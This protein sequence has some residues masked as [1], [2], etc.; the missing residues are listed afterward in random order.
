MR[1]GC[2]SMADSPTR[3]PSTS[4]RDRADIVIAGR[5]RRGA[6]SPKNRKIPNTIDLTIGSSQIL[7]H[8][9]VR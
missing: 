1:A 3:C 6:G 8:Q 2:W 5:R 7:M 4:L 9:V